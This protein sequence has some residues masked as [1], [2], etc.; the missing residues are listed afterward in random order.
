MHVAVPPEESGVGDRLGLPSTWFHHDIV[1]AS[2]AEAYLERGINPINFHHE[3]YGKERSE[4]DFLPRN[5]QDAINQLTGMA[6]AE[7]GQVIGKLPDHRAKEREMQEMYSEGPSV[8][9]PWLAE[10]QEYYRDMSKRH[11]PIGMDG[12]LPLEMLPNAGTLHTSP[13]FSTTYV[14]IDMP[15]RVHELVTPADPGINTAVATRLAMNGEPY[16]SSFGTNTMRNTLWR[17]MNHLQYFGQAD[18]KGRVNGRALLG[19]VSA[20]VPIPADMR[21]FNIEQIKAVPLR[22][23]DTGEVLRGWQADMAPMEA[24]EANTANA[25]YYAAGA[26]ENAVYALT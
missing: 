26:Y 12:V 16:P 25:E 22:D 7:N 3:A 5:G 23:E 18:G 24:R 21:T 17:H 4:P 8:M 10:I 2:E 19:N 11:I 15:H 14:D 20:L 1:Q 9:E 13:K 6:P